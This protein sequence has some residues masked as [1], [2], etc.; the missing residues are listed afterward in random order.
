MREYRLYFGDR[1]GA[2]GTVRTVWLATDEAAVDVA[3][4]LLAQIPGIDVWQG[5][6]RVALLRA[7]ATSLRPASSA[8]RSTTSYRETPDAHPAAQ[9]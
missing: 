5:E 3:R 8:D 7:D 2:F 6:R 4:R 1:D 9:P